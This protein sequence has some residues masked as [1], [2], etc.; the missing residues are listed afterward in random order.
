MPTTFRTWLRAERGASAVSLLAIVATLA[1]IAVIAVPALTKSG[2]SSDQTAS[3]T[4][5]AQD[6][7]A[8]T[9]LETGQ[10][11]MATYAATSN[12]G[13]TGVSPGA[14]S[15]IEP[16]LITQSTTEAYISAASGSATG[17]TL[18]ATD[19]LS[20]APF[21]LT[22]TSGASPRTCA[23]AGRGICSASGTF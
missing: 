5:Q 21:P 23:P 11:A 18:V 16:T 6:Q 1:I 8:Q 2:A 7:Q 9:L 12:N 13:Y 19:P 3:A 20:G 10:T 15:A 14:L 22:N 17:Y 4:A